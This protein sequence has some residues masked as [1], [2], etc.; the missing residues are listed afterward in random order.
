MTAHIRLVSPPGEERRDLEGEGAEADEAP[1]GLPEESRSQAADA[2]AKTG[3]RGAGEDD[4][5]GDWIHGDA[6]PPLVAEPEDRAGRRPG[7]KTVLGGALARLIDRAWPRKRTGTTAPGEAESESGD[8]KKDAG[9]GATV[10]PAGGAAIEDRAGL[11]PQPMARLDA[12]ARLIGRAS[13]RKPKAAAPSELGSPDGGLEGDKAGSGVEGAADSGKPVRSRGSAR[14]TIAVVLLTGAAAAAIV[15]WNWPHAARRPQIVEPGLIADQPSK[16]MAPSAALARVPPREEPN[17]AG[18]RPRVH[19]ARGDQVE[20]ML[21]FKP[22]SASASGASPDAR[23]PQPLLASA[24][25]KAASAPAAVALR[26][27]SCSSISVSR[28]CTRSSVPPGFTHQSV[29]QMRENPHP[30]LSRCS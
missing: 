18:E 6:P 3:S 8:R 4:R 12:L 10:I 11:R 17:V 21:S 30:S 7:P 13:Q 27:R 24:P 2:H 19:Q 23:G 1:L 15:A 25:E 9:S 16:L 20:E 29:D 28:A 26:C 5:Q 14:G 22:G